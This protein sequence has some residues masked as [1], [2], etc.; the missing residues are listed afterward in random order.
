LSGLYMLVALVGVLWIL[1][2]LIPAQVNPTSAQGTQI[3][4][5]TFNLY[6]EN[7]SLGEVSAWISA[8]VPDIVALQEM[9]DDMSAFDELENVYNERS[10]Q[11]IERG[12]IVYTQYPILETGDIEIENAVIQ[13]LV[14]D[15]NGTEVA[16]Y[17]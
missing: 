6:P 7:D 3:D 8:S 12:N 4:L 10:A 5:I 9:P 17:N 13:R 11:T 15:I 2:P 16:L 1:P 14:L